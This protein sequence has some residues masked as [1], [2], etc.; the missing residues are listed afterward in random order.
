MDAKVPFGLRGRTIKLIGLGAF[1]SLLLTL[2]TYSSSVSSTVSRFGFKTPPAQGSCPPRA[3]A[4]GSW[5][6]KAE[7]PTNLTRMT[8]SA[9]ALEFMGYEACASS[10][11]YWWHLAA[12]KEEQWDRFPGAT[13]WE[14]TPGDD[15]DIRPFARSALLRHLVEDG[16]WLLIGDSVTENH[17]FSLSCL[18]Y[19]DVRATPDYNLNPYLDR[20]SPQNLYLDPNSELIPYLSFPPGFNV[21]TTPL[22]T[23]RRVD[24]LL[25]RPEIE[26]IYHEMHHPPPEFN[27]FSDEAYWSLSPRDYMEIFY[28]PL[29]EGNYGTLIVSTG[30]HWTT[31]LLGGLRNNTAADNGIAAV[32]ELFQES[33]RVWADEV[34][35]AIW[36]SGDTSKQVVIRAYLPGHEDCHSQRQPWTEYQ[37]FRW[38]WYNWPDIKDFNAIFEEVVAPPSPYRNIHYLPID[39]PA[40]LRPDAHA[41]GDCLHIMSGAGVL[42]GWS[43][44]IWHYLT[45]ELPDRIR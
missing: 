35:Q 43:H 44:Y 29:P 27:L 19:P 8:K 39:R 28:R 25:D 5:T 6:R 17:F 21:S 15:C 10:R 42:E 38:G 22:V 3:W 2:Y 31:T 23:F 45:H 14:W 16:G 34:Q 20:A 1:V 24:L 33:M 9:D 30:G 7:L 12:D 36:H 11:E 32:L 4:N 41:T 40:L 37:P 18:L 13:S 26:D